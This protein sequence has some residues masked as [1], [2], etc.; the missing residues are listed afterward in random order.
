MRYITDATDLD[1]LLAW[2]DRNR[3][4]GV[5]TE[6]TG[7]DPHVDKVLLFQVGTELDQYVINVAKVGDEFVRQVLYKLNEEVRTNI[8]HNAKFDYQM[9]KGHFGVELKNMVCTMLA[10]QLIT[11]GLQVE[12]NLLAVVKKFTGVI[13]DK[14]VRGEF[15]GKKVGEE[16]LPAEIEYAANDVKY[17]IPIYKKLQE[18]LIARNM[19]I[20]AK[21][22][23]RT[24]KVTGDMEFN[25]IYVDKKLWLDLKNYASKEQRVIKDK[26]DKLVEGICEVDLFGTLLSPVTKKSSNS[27]EALNYNSNAQMLYLVNKITGH[28]VT[29]TGKEVLKSIDHPFTKLLAEYRAYT[30]LITTYGE[31]FLNQNI[32]PVTNRIHCTFKQ[33][34]AESGRY[35]STEP[36][37]QNIPRAQ[38]YRD[39][40]CVSDDNYRIVSADFSGQELRLLAELSEEPEFKKALEED[41]DLHSY[42]ASLLFDI[43]YEDFFEYDENGNIKIDSAGDPVIKKEMK[44]K[45]RN[46][47]KSITF[48]LI[49]GMGPGKLAR[50]L[51]I[52]LD[53]AKK[54]MKSYFAK[55]PKISD[56][57]K[58]IEKETRERK[59]AYSYLDN[60]IR[61]FNNLDWSDN[62]KVAHAINQAKNLP[63]QGAGASVTKLALVYI[64]SEIA[65]EK[66]DA[67]ILIVVH[68]E[69]LVEVHKDQAEYCAKIVQD[70]MIKAFNYY[71]PNT[72]MTV[73]PEIDLRWK[74]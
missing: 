56:L 16:F 62:G 50:T 66:L 34:G 55:F 39:P 51:E 69:I 10:N 38:K 14:E 23:Y 74:H 31:E 64:D 60:R 63:F 41:K 19:D 40:F 49:Y 3:V 33:L 27:P 54:L 65:K 43:P 29:S 45:Y 28:H 67:K 72:P 42:S 59:Y 37:M 53:E 17:L 22:E 35:S 2:L 32:H 61:Y 52:S 58:R 24:V 1:I 6:T 57:M 70:C 26:L 48:G 25:G 68:D 21:L 7:L 47:A 13:L 36:N 12:N 30:K 44:T 46:P 71:A 15:I 9:I 73:K 20:L 4:V 8:L 18:H 11:A 5:D